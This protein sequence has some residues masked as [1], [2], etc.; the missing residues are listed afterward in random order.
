M[1]LLNAGEWNALLG[2][3]SLPSHLPLLALVKPLAAT[4]H[5]LREKHTSKAVWYALW[6]VGKS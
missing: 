6:D 5:A 1:L 4:A 2:G 3:A